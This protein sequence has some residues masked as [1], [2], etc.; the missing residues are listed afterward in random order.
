LNCD[1]VTLTSPTLAAAVPG[2]P[3]IDRRCPLRQVPAPGRARCRQT[4]KNFMPLAVAVAQQ[5]LLR[6]SS[7]GFPL[8]L[9]LGHMGYLRLRTW[10][11]WSAV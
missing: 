8:H 7:L 10:R 5:L 3:G 6:A 4:Y 2:R 1:A 11:V 9:S